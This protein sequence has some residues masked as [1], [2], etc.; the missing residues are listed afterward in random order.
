MNI[1]I[2]ISHNYSMK[3]SIKTKF[4]FIKT[5]FKLNT[6]EKNS[7]NSCNQEMSPNHTI[8]IVTYKSIGS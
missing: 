1:I 2:I 4:F 6:L 3:F 8:H 5:K 7:S